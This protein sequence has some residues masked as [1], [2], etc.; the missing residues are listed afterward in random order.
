[1]S[2]VGKLEGMIFSG[3]VHVH[4]SG[5][6]FPYSYY[7]VPQRT[8][9][10]PMFV[11]DMES[12]GIHPDEKSLLEGIWADMRDQIL[13]DIY[14]DWL[15]EQGRRETSQAVRDG[16]VPGYGPASLKNAGVASGGTYYR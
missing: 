11:Y 15:E 10:S 2:R 9:P 1:M 8:M 16:Y 6:L 13:R 14:A 7:N 3:A 5:S 12:R 4:P